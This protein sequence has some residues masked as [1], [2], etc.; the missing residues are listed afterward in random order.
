VTGHTGSDLL[1]I[2]EGPSLAEALLVQLAKSS[3]A[4]V[5]GISDRVEIVET[6]FLVQDPKFLVLILDHSLKQ[7]LLNL[8]SISFC[9]LFS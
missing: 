8:A 1:V 4:S 7:V 2:L 6:V 3:A 9:R 5:V